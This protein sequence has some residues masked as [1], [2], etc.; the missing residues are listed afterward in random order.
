METEVSS[1][2]L[3]QAVQG[4]AH[5]GG[6]RNSW[7]GQE[8]GYQGIAK[9]PLGMPTLPTSFAPCLTPRSQSLTVHPHCRY[10]FL[11]MG[12][13]LEEVSLTSRG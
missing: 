4:N 8:G 7:D 10:S 2:L 6:K 11:H 9:L 5:Q 3:A 12:C 13:N 1:D